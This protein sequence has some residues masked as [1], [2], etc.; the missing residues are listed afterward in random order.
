M[1]V[2]RYD[3][4]DASGQFVERYWRPLHIPLFNDKRELVW[5][6]TQLEDVTDQMTN[7]QPSP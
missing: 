1:D 6:V 2:Q 3:V 4:R 7:G 5:L